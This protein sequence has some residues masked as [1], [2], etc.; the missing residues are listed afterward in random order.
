MSPLVYTVGHSTR[1][2]TEFV[3]LLH[4]Y[5]IA[6]VADVRSVPHSA[7]NPLEGDA[8]SALPSLSRTA[9]PRL[10]HFGSAHRPN[11]PASQTPLRIPPKGC[12]SAELWV[13][14]CWS[15]AS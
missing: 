1:S 15:C 9:W 13:A 3:A 7:H 6:L 8:H 10:N 14:T 4:E 2:A 12:L 11:A 5:G